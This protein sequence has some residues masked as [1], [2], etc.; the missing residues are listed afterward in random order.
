MTKRFSIDLEYVLSIFHRKVRTIDECDFLITYL[1]S[2]PDFKKYLTNKSRD[3]SRKIISCMQLEI[4]PKNAVLFHKGALSDKFYILLW[5]SLEALHTDKD[6][7]IIPYG[8]VYPGKQVGERGLVRKQPR[9]LTIKAK[10]ISYTLVLNSEDFTKYLGQDANIQLERKLE[11][12]DMYFPKIYSVSQLQKERIA[13]SMGYDEYKKN[14]VILEKDE[15]NDA[16]YF[17]WEGEVSLNYSSEA[18]GRVVTLVSGNCFGEEGAL[19]NRNNYYQVVVL[20]EKALIYS[21]K[22]TDLKIVPEDTKEAWRNNFN[23]KEKGRRLLIQ[24][25][26]DRMRT[27][28]IDICTQTDVSIYP[29]ASR[30]AQRRLKEINIRSLAISSKRM[31]DL[32]C[33]DIQQVMNT[34]RDSK[35]RNSRRR[36]EKVCSRSFDSSTPIR[37]TPSPLMLI[38]KLK[39]TQPKRIKVNTLL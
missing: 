9:S 33:I 16:L 14:S 6:G 8:S 27:G 3:I 26:L 31:S 30:Y 36:S 10:E 1:S 28:S 5:G 2:L 29:Q 11:I 34:S 32:T 23:L 35:S 39:K 7:Y 19:A 4:H 21:I 12:I 22:R 15:L 20:S 38:Q 13:F 25:R 37:C 17:I 24:H 18:S